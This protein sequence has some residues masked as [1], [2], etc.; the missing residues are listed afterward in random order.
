MCLWYKVLCSMDTAGEHKRETEIHILPP[1]CN[2]A[3]PKESALQRGLAQLPLLFFCLQVPRESLS[4]GQNKVQEHLAVSCKH[5][6]SPCS[7]NFHCGTQLLIKE[8]YPVISPS[9]VWRCCLDIRWL[10]GSP[11][12]AAVSRKQNDNCMEN[13]NK[14]YPVHSSRESLYH[15]L[16]QYCTIDSLRHASKQ[17]ISLKSNFL[18]GCRS[19]NILG[20][21]TN[22][23]LQQ[24]FVLLG[25]LTG[26]IHLVS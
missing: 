16:K 20:T 21:E 10:S 5:S 6:L 1:D 18:M 9:Q 2:K 15:K 23:I 12:I 17:L 24:P 11:C 26:C 22:A 7:G 8:S 25:N 4:D 19:E 3:K 13:M 14:T